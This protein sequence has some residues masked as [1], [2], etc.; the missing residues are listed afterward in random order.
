MVENHLKKFF[1]VLLYW[2]EL[3]FPIKTGNPNNADY[4]GD[5]SLIKAIWMTSNSNIEADQITHI[6]QEL[7]RAGIKKYDFI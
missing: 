3:N 4:N 2:F 7:V 5:T 1:Y 6:C